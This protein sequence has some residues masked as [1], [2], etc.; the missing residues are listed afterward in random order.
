M[1]QF[2][3]T[4]GGTFDAKK[5]R[6]SVPAAYRQLLTQMGATALVLRKSS[7]SECIE[8]W[9]QPDFEREVN[10][11]IEALDPFAPDYNRRVAKLVGRASTLSPDA[12]GRIVIPAPLIA[13]AGLEGEVSFAGRAKFF[14]L[15]HAPKLVAHEAAMDAEDAA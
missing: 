1:A 2:T 13:H 15:W 5:T 6:V 8:I 4:I 14:E 10:R 3:D 12:D 7:H 9:P 11:R